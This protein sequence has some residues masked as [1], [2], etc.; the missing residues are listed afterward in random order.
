MAIIIK[1]DYVKVEY[2]SDSVLMTE[3]LPELPAQFEERE[4]V[5]S[6]Y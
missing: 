2:D 4:T 6:S 5:S 3:S 1:L